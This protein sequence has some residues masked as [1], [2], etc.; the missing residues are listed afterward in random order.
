MSQVEGQTPEPGSERAFDARGEHRW[1]VGAVRWCGASLSH[2]PR[3]R[4]LR[5]P[6]APLASSERT[7]DAGARSLELLP[8]GMVSPLRLVAGLLTA[9]AMAALGLGVDIRG[10]A[11]TGRAVVL[12]ASGSLAV[13]AVLSF[14]LV[15]LLGMR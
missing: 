5:W 11:S 2:G 3:T 8:E 7:S 12:T 4:V 10:L 14:G 1:T 15:K 13:L 9:A 6:R